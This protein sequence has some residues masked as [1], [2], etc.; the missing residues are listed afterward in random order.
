MY[1][2]LSFFLIIL[3]IQSP[4]IIA[5]QMCSRATSFAIVAHVRFRACPVEETVVRLT[6]CGRLLQALLPLRWGH[7]RQGLVVVVVVDQRTVQ[8]DRRTDSPQ[9][10]PR[11]ADIWSWTHGR[12]CPPTW[13]KPVPL[14][15][16]Q[17]VNRNTSLSSRRF[18]SAL[19][20]VS[21]I[22]GLLSVSKQDFIYIA[23]YIAPF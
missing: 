1:F 3:F 6:F 10:P 22:Q 20:T 14:E 17:T 15:S 16:L 5:A 11:L 7:S 23:P 9:I 13:A 2:F 4:F 8:T 12:M 19:S 18:T 21:E